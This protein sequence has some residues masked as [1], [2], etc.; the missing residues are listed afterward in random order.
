MILEKHICQLNTKKIHIHFIANNVVF[1]AII[2]PFV[3]SL[4][5]QFLR[6][7]VKSTSE[8]GFDF[9]RLPTNIQAG[10]P[11]VHEQ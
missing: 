4:S 2:T 6:A 3:L 8:W 11:D 5:T 9:A 1:I 7:T 10:N